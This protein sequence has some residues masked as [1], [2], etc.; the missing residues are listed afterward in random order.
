MS[1]ISRYLTTLNPLDIWTLAFMALLGILSLIYLVIRGLSKLELRAHVG[2]GEASLSGVNPDPGKPGLKTRPALSSGPN[3]YLIEIVVISQGLNHHILIRASS[4]IFEYKFNG[5]VYEIE[6]GSVYLKKP[7][8]VES[9]IWRF[10]GIRASYMVLFWE[11]ERKPIEM[12][13]NRVNPEVLA[14]VRTSRALGKALKEMFKASLFDN[15][16]LIF[17]IIVFTVIGLILARTMG[18][19]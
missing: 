9:L 19:V 12:D 7:N 14:R 16:G 15:R 3:P 11:G 13:K 10:K 8:L 4:L 17:I 6:E 2:A 18:Y 5:R 1:W